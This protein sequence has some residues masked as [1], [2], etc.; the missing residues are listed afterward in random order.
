[1]SISIVAGKDAEEAAQLSDYVRD[2]NIRSEFVGAVIPEVENACVR[3]RVT[4]SRCH[5]YPFSCPLAEILSQLSM[6]HPVNVLCARFVASGGEKLGQ[7]FGYCSGAH[8]VPFSGAG[9]VG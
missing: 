3:P 9:I 7:G 6:A 2:S 1:M 8:R 5:A 4:C